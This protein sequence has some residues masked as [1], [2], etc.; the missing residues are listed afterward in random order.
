MKDSQLVVSL[1]LWRLLVARLLV[2]WLLVWKLHPLW[3][4]PSMLAKCFILQCLQ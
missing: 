1:A 3:K 4:L 2:S